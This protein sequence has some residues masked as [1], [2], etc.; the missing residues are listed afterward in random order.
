MTPIPHEHHSLMEAT[1]S[2]V[3]IGGDYVVLAPSAKTAQA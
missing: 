1:V 2:S 3:M